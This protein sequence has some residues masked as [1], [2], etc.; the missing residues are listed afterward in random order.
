MG[1]WKTRIEERKPLGASPAAIT[2]AMICAREQ[3]EEMERKALELEREPAA[4]C[5]L[6]DLQA[7]VRPARHP[8]YLQW[9]RT[10]PYS[11]CHT[12]RAQKLRLWRRRIIRTCRGQK[13][14]TFSLRAGP[15]SVEATDETAIPSEYNGCSPPPGTRSQGLSNCW[16]RD[17]SL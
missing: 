13:T 8:E 11:V 9:I 14:I 7:P 16:Y 12:T 5:N 10:L 15:P 4:T 17:F 1:R 6:I 3:L 2:L